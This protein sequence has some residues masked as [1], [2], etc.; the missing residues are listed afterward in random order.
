MQHSLGLHPHPKFEFVGRH[1]DEV[2]GHIFR[3]ESVHARAARPAVDA[4]KLVLDEDLALLGNEPVE[5]LFQ[6]AIAR[7][8]VFRLLQVINDA[9]AILGAHL[10]FFTAHVIA[11][12]LLGGEDPQVF[13]VIL[14]ANG[15]RSFEHHVLEEMRN[16]GDAWPFV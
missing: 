16:A 1:I 7:G 2:G 3:G 14:G 4:V 12:A 10:P 15:G 8:L 5:L 11:D 9:A 6:L 13:L